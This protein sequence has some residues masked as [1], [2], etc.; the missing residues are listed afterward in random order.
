L[1]PEE[2]DKKSKSLETD[3]GIPGKDPWCTLSSYG[4][5]SAFDEKEL[6]ELI[7]PN[8]EGGLIWTIQLVREGTPIKPRRGMPFPVTA[9]DFLSSVKRVGTPSVQAHAKAGYDDLY[10]RDARHESSDLEPE[11]ARWVFKGVLNGWPGLSLL[12]VRKSAP[13]NLRLY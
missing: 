9:K 13:K 2:K 3:P 11:E 10:D 8:Q 1:P 12:E 5:A 7:G 4:G 6:K